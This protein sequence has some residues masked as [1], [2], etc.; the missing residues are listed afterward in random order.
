[1]LDYSAQFLIDLP[2]ALSTWTD[3][4]LPHSPSVC[5]G[6][7]MLMRLSEMHELEPVLAPERVN[8]LERCELKGAT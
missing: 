2:F 8:D 7:E 3:T 4:D 6:F 5:L 1:M